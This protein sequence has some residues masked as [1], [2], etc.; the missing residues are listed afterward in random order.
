MLS[1]LVGASRVQDTERE[2]V[3]GK[4]ACGFE[5]EP[6]PQRVNGGRAGTRGPHGL[7]AGL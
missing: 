3:S 1:R 7:A 2:V 6:G 5:H 4:S